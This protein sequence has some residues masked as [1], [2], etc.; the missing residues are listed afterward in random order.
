MRLQTTHKSGDQYWP[1]PSVNDVPGSLS[2]GDV[3]HVAYHRTSYTTGLILLAVCLLVQLDDS[4]R[5]HDVQ[6]VL[7]ML[8]HDRLDAT[9]IA[10]EPMSSNQRA[11]VEKLLNIDTHPCTTQQRMLSRIQSLLEQELY[12]YV[13]EQNPE[14]LQKQ[15]IYCAEQT[16][17]TE[18]DTNE[19]RKLVTDCLDGS[20]Y[21]SD[22]LRQTIPLRNLASHP[23]DWSQQHVNSIEAAKHVL[24]YINSGEKI[25]WV[26]VSELFFLF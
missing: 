6:L 12:Q 16:E 4:V 5:L 18:W 17:L 24:R 10:Q 26:R 8:Y 20:Y 23:S 13:Y 7:K 19:K 3:R 14:S 1:A 15:G 11:D 25:A 2:V 9:G 22:W 21:F